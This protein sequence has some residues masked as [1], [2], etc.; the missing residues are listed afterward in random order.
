MHSNRL[1][2]R[3]ADLIAIPDFAPGAMENWG[4]ITFRETKLLRDEGGA[5]YAEMLPSRQRGARVGSL[6]VRRLGLHQMVE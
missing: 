5:T 6:V 2:K 3:R 1:I 4:L